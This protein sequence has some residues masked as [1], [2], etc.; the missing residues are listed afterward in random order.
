MYI[1]DDW[2]I[3]RNLT[4]N[5][6]V[7]NEYETAW[8]DPLHQLSRGLDLTSTDPAIAANLPQLPSAATAIVGSN[9]AS[10]AGQ[11]HFTDSF[12]TGMWNAPKLA[13]QPR[14]GAAYRINDRTA[15]RFGYAL[16]TVPSE[17]NFTPAPVSGSKT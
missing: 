13:L 6:G 15:L 10:F 7:R 4:L 2:K 12:N 11:W 16:Y 17:Y 9:Y 8:H 3:K 1:G 14:F 5:F